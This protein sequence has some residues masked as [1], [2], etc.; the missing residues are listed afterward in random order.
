MAELVDLNT[1]VSD[2]GEVLDLLLF[3]AREEGRTECETALF[4]AGATFTAYPPD[5]DPPLVP[6]EVIVEDG[7]VSVLA[8]SLFVVSS[9]ETPVADLLAVDR[10]VLYVLRKPYDPECPT[11][12]RVLAA[13]LPVTFPERR[14]ET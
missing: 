5:A 6:G 14:K 13:T 8:G 9:M 4:R 12:R 2:S 3:N 10:A 1:R 7:K 11:Q